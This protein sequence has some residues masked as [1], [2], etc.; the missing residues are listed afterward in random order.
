M[1]DKSH[2]PNVYNI[3]VTKKMGEIINGINLL[4]I[5]LLLNQDNFNLNAYIELLTNAMKDLPKTDKAISNSNCA[6]AM[7]SIF[8]DYSLNLSHNKPPRKQI[9]ELYKI[10]IYFM[11]HVLNKAEPPAMRT[12]EIPITIDGY[13]IKL[14]DDQIVPVAHDVAMSYDTIKNVID[15]IVGEPGELIALHYNDSE[16][17]YLVLATNIFITKNEFD[18]FIRIIKAVDFLGNDNILNRVLVKLGQMFEQEEFLATIRPMKDRVQELL[19]GL[20]ETIIHRFFELV[21]IPVIEYT[22]QIDKYNERLI[23]SDDLNHF[24]VVECINDE[25]EDERIKYDMYNK[26][27]CYRGFTVNHSHN[28][29]DAIGKWALSN[30]GNLYAAT[31]NMNVSNELDDHRIAIDMGNDTIYEYC[32][33]DNYTEHISAIMGDRASIIQNI[34]Q[35]T[36]RCTVMYH[37]TNDKVTYEVRERAVNQHFS[38]DDR[39]LST[40][41]LP[42]LQHEYHNNSIVHGVFIS[43]N[44]TKMTKLPCASPQMK[45]IIYQTPDDLK[46]AKYRILCPDTNSTAIIDLNAKPYNMSNGTRTNLSG[47]IEKLPIDMIGSDRISK[48]AMS[49]MLY[50]HDEKKFAIVFRSN[51]YEYCVCIYSLTGIMLKYFIFNKEVPIVLGNNYIITIDSIYHVINPALYRKLLYHKLVNNLV[52]PADDTDIH[53]KVWSTVNPEKNILSYQTKIDL[54]IAPNAIW[55]VSNI[56]IGSNESLLIEYDYRN[57]GQLFKKILQKYTIKRYNDIKSFLDDKL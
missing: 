52:K 33:E 22:S 2:T 6:T 4:F 49:Y 17:L 34:S 36:K 53:I 3:L 35:D 45:I 8:K 31:I 41:T 11:L 21:N 16:A 54:S 44:P 37:L 18:V 13:I 12:I 43:N 57:P 24:V 7:L 10:I 14:S 1:A 50:S 56:W 28:V 9:L 46:K 48:S 39:V 23:V 40:I 55:R 32:A 19:M 26:G 25:R 30:D 29:D 15:N 20:P 5:T 27:L 42:H 47:G 51:K 38:S